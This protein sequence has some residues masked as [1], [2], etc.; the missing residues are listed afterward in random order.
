MAIVR[1]RMVSSVR[2]VEHHPPRT[3]SDPR[4]NGE[5][6]AP[7][8]EHATALALL[9]RKIETVDELRR[10]LEELRDLK[11]PHCGGKVVLESVARNPH[12]PSV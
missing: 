8:I 4:A 6:E 1:S 11:C 12:R 10:R 2:E 3:T 5:P 7:T 9:P